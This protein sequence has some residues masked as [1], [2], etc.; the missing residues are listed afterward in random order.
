MY[1]N[2]IRKRKEGRKEGRKKKNFK[3]K[4]CDK[5]KLWKSVAGSEKGVDEDFMEE[6]SP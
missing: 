3:N 4:G 2:K 5:R 6:R 1:K